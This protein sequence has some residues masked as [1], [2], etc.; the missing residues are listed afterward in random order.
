METWNKIVSTVLRPIEWL[1]ESIEKSKNE[2][3]Q[4]IEERKR[5]YREE[6]AAKRRQK[7]RQMIESINE[8]NKQSNLK[9]RR[10]FTT[11]QEYQKIAGPGCCNL[12]RLPDSERDLIARRVTELKSKNKKFA[13]ALEA[14]A[15]TGYEIPRKE[16]GN[17]RK[18]PHQDR[19]I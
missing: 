6:K 5:R 13:E 2:Q 11:I 15:K 18:I 4:K 14:W 3:R 16:V 7:E 12:D 1:I 19:R 9:L 10:T 17:V 8:K